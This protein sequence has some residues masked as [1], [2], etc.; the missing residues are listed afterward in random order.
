MR[1]ATTHKQQ[2]LL[3]FIETEIRRTGVSP[4]FDEMTVHMDLRSKSGIARLVDALVE[5][6]LLVRIPNRARAL[7]LPE[8]VGIDLPTS[9]V[10]AIRSLA[11]ERGI[12]SVE[13]VH[14]A[15]NAYAGQVSA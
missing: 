9:L 3:N 15:V 4:S 12:G 10:F 13:L 8:P 14:R 6:G 5:R 7:G 11:A 2:A 1:V